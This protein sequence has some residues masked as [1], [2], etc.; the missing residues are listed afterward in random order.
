MQFNQ[1]YFRRTAETH[2]QNDRADAAR[3]IHLRIFAPVQTARK[4]AARQNFLFLVAQSDLPAVRMSAKHQI[5]SGA[6]GTIQSFRIMCKQHLHFVGKRTA[7]SGGQISQSNH[8]IVCAA[9]PK[10]CAASRKPETFVD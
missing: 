10:R 4:P 6:G 1:R 7:Q 5:Y 9:E 3:D 2:G 8:I